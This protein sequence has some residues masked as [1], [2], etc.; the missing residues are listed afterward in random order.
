MCGFSGFQRSLIPL[1]WYGIPADV[2][3]AVAV[4]A[5]PVARQISGTTVNVDGGALA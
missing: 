5:S 2:A 1:R 4:L 3:A